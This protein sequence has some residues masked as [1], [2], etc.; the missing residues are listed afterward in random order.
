MKEIKAILRSF[1]IDE[2][3]F[4]L[5][6]IEGLP[7]LTVSEVKSFGKKR[8]EK[9]QRKPILKS[10]LEVVVA[11][12]MV[13]LVVSVIKQQAYTGNLGDGK[14]FIYDVKDVVKIRTDDRGEDA[15]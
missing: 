3:L 11:D 15:L 13:D 8:E 7:G 4:K 12:D 10:K 9:T 14:I 6:E 1:K 5:Y 2:V